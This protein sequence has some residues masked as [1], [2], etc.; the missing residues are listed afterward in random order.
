MFSQLPD[1]LS[2]SPRTR[3]ITIKLW[4]MFLRVERATIGKAVLVV[5]RQDGR[6]LALTSQASE[7]RLPV[8]ELDGWQAVPTQVQEWLEELLDQRLT[9]K[10][11]AV[12]GSPGREGIVFLYST[13]ASVLVSDHRCGV[14][15]DADIVPSMLASEDRH[16]IRLADRDALA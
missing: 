1:L 3:R 12:D 14:W 11:V 13:D 2:R 6:L 4:R 7:F 10:L 9:P 5:R 15:L 8:K 16:F